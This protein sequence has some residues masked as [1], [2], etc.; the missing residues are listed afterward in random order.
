MDDLPAVFRA[1]NFVFEQA[2]VDEL[3]IEQFRAEFCLPFKSFYDRYTPD[4]KMEQLEEWFHGRFRQVQDSVIELPHARDFLLFCRKHGIRTFLLSTVHRDH[5]AVQAGITG[6]AEF[7]DKPYVEILDKR[8]KIREILEENQLSAGETMFIGDMQHDVETAKHGNVFSCAVLTGYNRLE[9]LRASEPDLI[10]EH[11]G[12]LQEILT[13]NNFEI[14]HRLHGQEGSPMSHPICT[15]GA[16]IFNEADQVLMVRTQKWSNLWGIP[17]GKTKYGE[18]AAAALCR[19]IKEETNLEIADIEFVIVQDCIHSKEFY[20][21]AHFVLL[22]YSCRVRGSSD[23]TLNEEAQEFCWV[24]VDVALGMNVNQ[25]TRI[26]L[27]EIKHRI[28]R[29]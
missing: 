4:V 5:F 21:E 11:L 2:G 18:T 27:E 6:F 13:R 28:A 23:V 26:L 1:T 24:S 20:R 29:E 12:E 9:Q 17:G 16:A 14:T 3:T 8:M 7:I 25:P 10:V 15:V 19:E 22:N